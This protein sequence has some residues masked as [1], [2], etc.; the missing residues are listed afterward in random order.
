MEII[1]C[2]VMIPTASSYL[3]CR[4]EGQRRLA[5]CTHLPDDESMQRLDDLGPIH[6]IGVPVAKL[7]CR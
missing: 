6:A 4:G 7:A 2:P 3:S 5:A 1:G